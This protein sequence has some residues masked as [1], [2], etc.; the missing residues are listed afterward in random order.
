MLFAVFAAY[1]GVLFVLSRCL[2]WS[3]RLLGVTPSVE[4][5]TRVLLG[6][7]AAVVLIFIMRGLEALSAP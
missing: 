1:I 3:F 5:A 7:A 4:G 2:E 6:V